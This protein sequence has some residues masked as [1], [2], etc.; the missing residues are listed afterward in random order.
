MQRE[1]ENLIS[2]L[3]K[4]ADD[5]SSGSL[6]LV[7]GIFDAFESV[8]NLVLKEDDILKILERL[9]VLEKKQSGFVSVFNVISEIKNRLEDTDNLFSYINNTRLYYNNLSN[10]QTEIFLTTGLTPRNIL[11]H[12]NSRSVKYFLLALRNSGA[13]IRKIYQTVS[14]PGGEGEVQA[15]FL[16][17]KN[18][19]IELIDDDDVTD[20][21]SHIDIA[22]FGADLV[23][24]DG[25]INKAKTAT[26]CKIFQTAG[27]PVFVLADR[28][29]Q[30]N[31]DNAERFKTEL[32]K[33]KDKKGNML[34]EMVSNS[35]VTD[36]LIP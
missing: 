17:Q 14:L 6:D 28:L 4:I 33:I 13:D 7:F 18:F 16:G 27:V 9:S 3:L 11:V 15:R 35:L 20:A 21:V 5:R 32:L 8:R 30:V 24:H 25:F 29:K 12:S 1:V 26:I 10:K 2:K 36:F 34:F 19:N 22:F 23:L 31:S